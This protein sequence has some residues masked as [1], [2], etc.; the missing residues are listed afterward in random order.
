MDYK[1]ILS[2]ISIPISIIALFFTIRNYIRKSGTSIRGGYCI[3]SSAY[4]EDK[5][6]SSIVLENLKDRPVVI[7]K[8]FLRI[9]HNY[10]ITLDEFNDEPKIL[11]PYEAYSKNYDPIDFYS[12]SMRRIKL[13]ALIGNKKIT[14]K[15]VLSTSNGKYIVKQCIKKWDPLGDFFDNHLTAIIHPA[16]STYKN[17]CFGSEVKYIV[18]IKMK[19]GTEET[20]PI[21]PKDFEIRKFSKF[22]LTKESLSSK[23]SL[24]NFLLEKAIDGTIKCTNITVHDIESWR[25]DIYNEKSSEIIEAK[26]FNWVIYFI[27]GRLMTKISNARLYLANRNAKKINQMQPQI[28]Q[29]TT[30]PPDGLS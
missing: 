27:I 5:Y 28:S 24:E 15:I 1:L 17:K 18:D 26:H 21:Y 3:C 23:D 20:I 9:G 19:D 29:G 16:R 11:K 4:C 12:T 6:V 8:V 25:K 2:I 13:N 7:F 30:N 22:N 14:S 10:Y